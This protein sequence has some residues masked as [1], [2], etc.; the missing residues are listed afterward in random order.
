MRWYRLA[1]EQDYADAQYRLGV[2]YRDGE[3]VPEDLAQ[4]TRWFRMVAERGDPEGQYELGRMYESGEGVPEND[5]EAVRWYRLAAEQGHAGG[6]NNLGI[7]YAEGLGVLRDPAE[8]ERWLRMAAEQGVAEAQFNLGRMY[9]LRI[10]AVMPSR[11]GRWFGAV[12]E[13]EF[14]H[15]W[16]N[17]AIANGNEEGREALAAL[18]R[19]MTSDEISRAVELA[20]ACMAS[21]Y[22]DCKQ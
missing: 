8:A 18:E 22:Q 5:A 2:A 7:S 9:F 6:Q 19:D 10:D 14:A 3:G 20:R 12:D 16:L 15:M 11:L 4:A 17:I 21:D 1:A 13:I